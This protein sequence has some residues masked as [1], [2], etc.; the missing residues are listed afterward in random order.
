MVK[1]KRGNAGIEISR[2]V[3]S[4]VND[5]KGVLEDLKDEDYF[6]DYTLKDLSLEIDEILKEGRRKIQ[7]YYL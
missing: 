7:E 2:V 1:Q 3:L 6:E 5:L 4:I